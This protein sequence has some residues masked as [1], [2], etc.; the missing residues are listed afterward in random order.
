M[1]L[2]NLELDKLKKILGCQGGVSPVLGVILMVS[3]VVILAGIFSVAVFGAIPSEK[4][5]LTSI[6]IRDATWDGEHSITLF[7]KFGDSITK[8]NT[9]ITITDL[10]ET[11]NQHTTILSK[12]DGI[13]NKWSVGEKI[14]ITTDKIPQ[15]SQIEIRVIHEPSGKTIQVMTTTVTQLEPKDPTK[16]YSLNIEVE[17]EGTTNPAPGE[18]IFE[19]GDEVTI[20]TTPDEG[21]VFSEWTGD[22]QET[23]SEITITMDSDKTV[24]AI[25]EETDPD[26]VEY[27][28]TIDV[29]GEGTTNP[30]PGEHIFEEG[31]EVTIETTPDEGWVFSEWT[32]DIQETDS[33]ITIEMN[34]DIELIAV[35]ELEDEIYTPIELDFEHEGEGEYYWVLKDPPEQ[36]W[37]WYVNS[38]GAQI[39]E[40]NGED[41]TNQYSWN[42]DLPEPIDGN[43]YIH[44]IGNEEWS[45]FEAKS[46]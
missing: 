11:S 37:S 9:R 38:W 22:I 2:I 26:P 12:L 46:N 17:G 45:T 4:S 15:T 44:F 43:Y 10:E 29:E 30:A 7:H 41:F 36:D 16:E 40:I 32:G 24:T 31:D 5:P 18:H 27:T 39:V 6:E 33:E 19:E 42:Q 35:F 14:Q 13:D 28:L 8:E 1:S 34:N 23:D 20:E 3:I 21:W 25:F